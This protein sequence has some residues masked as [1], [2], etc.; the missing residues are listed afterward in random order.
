MPAENSRADER[1]PIARKGVRTF[2]HSL[3]VAVPSEDRGRDELPVRCALRLTG[4]MRRACRHANEVTTGNFSPRRPASARPAT[5]QRS[6]IEIV[7][8]GSNASTDHPTFAR[9]LL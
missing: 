3:R 4:L 8:T 5:R 1:A 7:S 2:L 9:L 6:I